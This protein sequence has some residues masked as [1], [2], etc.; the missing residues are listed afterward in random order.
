MSNSLR[1]KKIRYLA[2]KKQKPCNIGNKQMIIIQNI[3]F[4]NN[5]K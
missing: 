1:N 3:Y 4:E 2:K 5:N